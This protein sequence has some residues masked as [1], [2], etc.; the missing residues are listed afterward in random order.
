[1]KKG[2]FIIIFLYSN[3]LFAQEKLSFDYLVTYTYTTNYNIKNP[4]FTGLFDIAFNDSVSIYIKQKY[5]MYGAVNN[6]TEDA[7]QKN[8]IK[9]LP[10]SKPFSNGNS[11][12]NLGTVVVNNIKK[13]VI[14]FSEY[15]ILE[16]KITRTGYTEN[17]E[18]DWVLTE[19]TTTINGIL[20]KKA[21]SNMWGRSW[22][23]WYSEEF[24]FPYG[25]YKFYGLPGLII[26]IADSTGTHKYEVYEFK[27][28]TFSISKNT[29]YHYEPI[30]T[31]KQKFLELYD[32]TRFTMEVFKNTTFKSDE[33]YKEKEN[34]LKK[35][36]QEHNPIELKP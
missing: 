28:G 18:I 30:I 27:K 36:K 35:Y 22:E 19:D 23:C 29:L 6:I 12:F 21:T 9:A 4:L 32:R 7:I 10:P 1:M 25:P 33:E 16:G 3:I 15:L 34:Q 13:D 31:T 14:E 26:R 24:P 2:L 8:I 5:N 20:C 11:T 17:V